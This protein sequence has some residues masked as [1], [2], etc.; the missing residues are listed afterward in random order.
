VFLLRI[1][2]GLQSLG[3]EQSVKVQNQSVPAVGTVLGWVKWNVLNIYYA[4]HEIGRAH[5][6]I[7][8]K[9]ANFKFIAFTSLFATT[10]SKQV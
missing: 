6:F 5:V 10:G 9:T 4:R 7:G 8:C 2:L 1:A 3:R